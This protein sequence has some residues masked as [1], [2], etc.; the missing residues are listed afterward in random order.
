MAHELINFIH[1]E[2]NWRAILVEKPYCL[3][4]TEDDN[5]IMLKYNQIESD[6]KNA[7]VRE[8]RGIILKKET[9][10]VVCR[11]FDKFGNY[12]ES[13]VP[14]IDWESA[15][16]FEKV[17]GSLIKIFWDG[18]WRIA[19]NGCIDAN[20]A[21]VGDFGFSFGGLVSNILRRCSF[22]NWLNTI[23]TC[24][25]DEWHKDYTHLFEL[26]S[27]FNQ[28]VVRY[29]EPALYYLTSIHTQ[30]KEEVKF[31]EFKT[32]PQPKEYSLSTLQDCV[33]AAAELD[34][35]LEGFVVVDKFHQRVKVKNPAYVAAHHLLG[36]GMSKSKILDLVLTGEVEEALNY[37]P[38]LKNLILEVS[39]DIKRCQEK[40]FD[41]IALGQSLNH[42]DRKSAAEVINSTPNIYSAFAFQAL[43]GKA[44]QEI[45]STITNDRYKK[46]MGY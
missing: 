44:S 2:P 26:V 35:L 32:F 25:M 37:F 28:V 14:D 10:D 19:T 3:K 8:A 41:S 16:I 46:L 18:E 7:I 24:D 45:F 15:R 29:D 43:S 34:G 22:S 11:G 4:I 27:P 42:L 1:S 30:T 13:Y 17:D 40:V 38:H 23:N 31:D 5:Y 36:N 21:M 20:L 39:E 33:K 9:L 12:G 6:F